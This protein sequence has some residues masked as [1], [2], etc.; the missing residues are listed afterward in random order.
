MRGDRQPG[1]IESPAAWRRVGFAVAVG[2]ISSVGMWSVPVALPFVESDFGISRGEASLPYTL[3]MMGFALGGIAMG[4]LWDRF[5]LAVAV[6][7]GT[8]LLSAGY[9]GTSLAPTALIFALM[10]L[11]IGFGASAS[12]G[13]LMAEMSRWFD[14]HRG[15]AVALAACGNYVGGTVWPPVLQHA[16]AT[17][18]WRQAYLGTGIFCLLATLPFIFALRRRAPAH[19]IASKSDAAAAGL[20]RSLGISPNTLMALLCVAG[21]GCCVAMAMP[22]VQIVAYCGD[23]G[24]GPARGAE[25]LSAMLGLG[26]VSRIGSGLIADRLG[27]VATLLIGSVLQAIALFLYLWFDGLTSLY[28]ISALFGL[29]QGGIVPMY[30]VI[31]S[32]YF[33]PKEVGVR[34]GIALMATLF[35]M[36]LGGWMSGAIFDFTGSYR[37]AFLNG[38]IW[39]LTNV[40][41][42]SW[43]LLRPTRPLKT[44]PLAA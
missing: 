36:A 1:G 38:L 33:P 32:E 2:A 37:A 5:G 11:V 20:A 9:A 27:G 44:E 19:P 41:I 13:P 25:M 17:V 21:L 23:L 26:I 3:V 34:V 28:I 31:V 24:Y 30:A 4:R 15:I 8:L 42:V 22:Q 7:A 14:R 35:G 16:M 40:A 39:N 18:G 6:I 10:H 12:F 29:F 43:L